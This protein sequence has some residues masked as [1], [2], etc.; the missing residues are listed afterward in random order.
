MFNVTT[1]SAT[2]QGYVTGLCEIAKQAFYYAWKEFYADV[3]R[4]LHFVYEFCHFS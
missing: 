1:N 2:H 3:L 4:K